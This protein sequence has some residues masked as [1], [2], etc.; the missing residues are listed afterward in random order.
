MLDLIFVLH[1]TEEGKSNGQNPTG[2]YV[3]GRLTWTGWLE[4]PVPPATVPEPGTLALFG[5]GL[6]GLGWAR[7]KNK[8]K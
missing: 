7:K 8:K 1:N 2:L 6:A 4:P 5:L 3:D